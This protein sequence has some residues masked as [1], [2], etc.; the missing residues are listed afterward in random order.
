MD[1]NLE[2]LIRSNSV[3]NTL[4]EDM[5]EQEKEIRLQ[6]IAKEILMRNAVEDIKFEKGKKHYCFLLR[7]NIMLHYYEEFTIYPMIT[8]TKYFS[9]PTDPLAVLNNVYELFIKNKISKKELKWKR[10]SQLRLTHMDGIWA[11]ELGMEDFDSLVPLPKSDDKESEFD[12]K[13]SMENFSAWIKDS[14]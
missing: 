8:F 12:F 3:Q 5:S 6:A 2:I 7:Y 4:A 14:F 1:S 13:R 11:K 9:D 10:E